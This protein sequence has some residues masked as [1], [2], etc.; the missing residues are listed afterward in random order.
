M[1]TALTPYRRKGLLKLGLGHVVG[2]REGWSSL[3][4][5]G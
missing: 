2:G 3:E 5:Q 1:D 4:E